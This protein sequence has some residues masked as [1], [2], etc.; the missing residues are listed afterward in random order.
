[1]YRVHGIEEYKKK[2]VELL[3]QAVQ[4]WANY[5]EAATT[6]YYPQLYAR[7]QLLDWEANLEHVKHDVEIA[8]KAKHGD[9]VNVGD[10]VRLWERDK[11]RF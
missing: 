1:M 8:R 3:E 9:K 7:T 6:Y 11:T 4:A 5:T 2:A 10:Y